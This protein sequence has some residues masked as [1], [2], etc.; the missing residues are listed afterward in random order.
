MKMRVGGG[1]FK[2]HLN[3]Y[4]IYILKNMNRCLKR[5]GKNSQGWKF[6]LILGQRN[7]KKISRQT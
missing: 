4:P 5:S 1:I 6:F 3:R 7:L 2:F